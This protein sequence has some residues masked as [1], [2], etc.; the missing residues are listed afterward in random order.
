M[1]LL[2]MTM[3]DFM[4]FEKDGDTWQAD[5]MK[6]WDDT[7]M[8]LRQRRKRWD[9][10]MTK[11]LVCC[12]VYPKFCIFHDLVKIYGRNIQTLYSTNDNSI[13]DKRFETHLKL[14][15]R[16]KMRNAWRCEGLT[17]ED[18]W[19]TNKMVNDNV[20]ESDVKT[21]LELA[22]NDDESMSFNPPLW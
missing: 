20:S 1:T 7:E 21:I 5:V 12:T 18:S 13:D 11:L 3:Q 19:S 9:Y 15:S 10:E 2:I 4:T 22:W 16:T 8:I 6:R 17:N 14:E